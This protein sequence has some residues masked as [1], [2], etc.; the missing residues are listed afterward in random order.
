MEFVTSLSSYLTKN[1]R[2]IYTLEFLSS[3][4]RNSLLYIFVFIY[5]IIYYFIYIYLYIILLHYYY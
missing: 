3:N 5:L 4:S 2:P 1:L